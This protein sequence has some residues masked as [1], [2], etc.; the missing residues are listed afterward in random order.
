[1]NF[2]SSFF[3]FF[4]KSDAFACLESEF[5]NGF[6]PYNSIDDFM[7]LILDILIN[8]LPS[9]DSLIDKEFAEQII[10]RLHCLRKEEPVISHDLVIRN[11]NCREETLNKKDAHQLHIKFLRTLCNKF[12]DYLE[13]TNNSFEI[14]QLSSVI[15]TYRAT[16]NCNVFGFLK[17]NLSKINEYVFEDE[18]GT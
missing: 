6:P 11:V 4:L 2:S 12:V 5:L 17:R 7:K 16:L 18:T 13:S 14:K 15:N 3:S 1:M 10:K 8:K 9:D